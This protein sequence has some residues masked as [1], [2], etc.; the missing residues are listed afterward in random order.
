MK[1]EN[2]QV[3]RRIGIRKAYENYIRML[4]AVEGLDAVN[5][6]IIF[7]EADSNDFYY[8]VVYIEEVMG[9]YIF[10]LTLNRIFDSLREYLVNNKYEIFGGIRLVIRIRGA[11][12]NIAEAEAVY[13]I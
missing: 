4:K 11:L 2:N 10:S 3:R 12:F 5:I 8:C 7:R 6:P 13:L 9:E 1:N